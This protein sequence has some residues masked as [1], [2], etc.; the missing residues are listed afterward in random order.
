VQLT[1]VDGIPAFVADG[2]AP[3]SAGLVFGIGR[4]DEPFVR[5]GITHLVE[6][7][8]MSAVGRRVIEV[9]A[10]VDLT[11]TEFTATGP[12]D[13]VVAFLQA[14]CRALSDLPTDR[15]A[16][17]ADVL[18]VEDGSAAPPAVALMLSE[19][20]GPA[21]PGLAAAPELGLGSITAADVRNWVARWFCRQNA[22]LWT[23][24]S[25]PDELTL[26]LPGGPRPVR[27]RV[28]PLPLATPA[29]A[30]SPLEC[31]ITLGARLPAE[32]PSG[33]LLEVLRVRVEDEFRHR[34]GIAYAVEVDRFSVAPE[35]TVVVLTT[36]VLAGQEQLAARLLWRA[37]EDLAATGP[38]LAELDREK[39]MT[40]IALDDPRSAVEEARAH[41]QAAVAGVAVRPSAQVREE[42]AALGVED[43][44]QTASALRDA[45]LLTIP[46]PAEP[47]SADLARVPEWSADLVAGTEYRPARRAL[48]P[49]G[50]RL[51]VGQDGVSLALGD[52]QQVTVR[53]ADAVGLVRDEADGVQVY[54][55]DGF[56][57]RLAADD[58]RDGRHALEAVLAA[59]PRELQATSPGAGESG[60]LLFRA[61]AHKI[62]EA[63]AGS[64]LDVRLA[65]N[66]EWT[67]VVL[68][69][70]R[71]LEQVVAEL[72]PMIGGKVVSLIL[73][74]GH[75]DLEYVLLRGGRE[76]D[77]HRSGFRAS[78]RGDF[79]PPEGTRGSMDRWRHLSR[80]RPAWYRAVNAAAALA[81]GLV[82]WLLI[83]TPDLWGGAAVVRGALLVVAVVGLA[84]FLWDTRPPSARPVDDHQPGAEMATY[85]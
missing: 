38:R 6:H 2:P 46:E 69:V 17:E 33:A 74:P 5:G 13:E 4:R 9:N 67:F 47:P 85:G 76:V 40:A 75:A 1:S 57:A 50:A 30:P 25:V 27:A 21:G 18:R 41:A 36:D 19:L 49:R 61:P 34:R 81:S 35:E 71:P 79:L 29:W 77:R 82:M 48:A 12:V 23:S 31:R 55:R 45:A 72:S 68:D 22:A 84:S 8:T 11:T 54:G 10:S 52:D 63:V 42:T 83:T 56:V 51:V 73:R 70:P 28:E 65:S 78:V 7:L 66:A 80:T 26:M 32:L 15:L 16:V 60:V 39:T 44:R 43:L 20:Y 59:V 3:F 62:R 37:V 53:W 24:A 58:W 64:R 14:V